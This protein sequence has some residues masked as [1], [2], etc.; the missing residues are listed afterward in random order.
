MIDEH[1]IPPRTGDAP[2]AYSAVI[3]VYNSAGVVGD[4][5]DACVTFFEKRKLT[6]EIIAVDDGSTDSSW[7]VLQSRAAANP[8]VI[9][10]RLLRNYGQHSALHCGLGLSRGE[11]AIILDDD[12]QN[13]PDEII[14]L[15]RSAEEGADVVFG[16]YLNK[17]HSLT[18][19]IGSWLTNHVN[20]AV[21]D[22][23]GNLVLT[24]FKLIER[25]VVDRILAHRTHF[26]YINGLAVLY[27][28]NPVNVVVEHRERTIGKSNY[29][30]SKIIE[31]LT[32]ILFNYSAFPLRLLTLSGMIVAVFSFTLATYVFAKAL[33]VGT[34][35]P[36]WASVAVMLAFFNGMTL[37]LLG[38]LG[39]Y[40]VRILK[41][42]SRTDPYHVVEVAR[43]DAG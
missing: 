2:P 29:K 22:K 6:Y 25:R 27:A 43:T 42:T 4:A 31:L 5:I 33:L 36:G 34:S 18:R 35:V 15:I 32:R 24:N 40:V 23:P 17:R 19:R 14:H 9:A 39:E 10:V 13:P 12:L 30:L 28:R 41:Q 37:L 7:E 1:P 38:V 20:T 21:F 11:Y 16:K 8:Y 26:P 3:P